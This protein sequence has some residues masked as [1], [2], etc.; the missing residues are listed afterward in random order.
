MGYDAHRPTKEVAKSL[1]HKSDK[2]LAEQHQAAMDMDDRRMDQRAHLRRNIR[3]YITP[4][5]TIS[6]RAMKKRANIANLI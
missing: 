2:D 5:P 4:C 6:Y 3:L 1:L